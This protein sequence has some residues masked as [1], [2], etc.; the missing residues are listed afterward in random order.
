MILKKRIGRSRFYDLLHKG[1]VSASVAVSLVG[2]GVLS[3]QVYE[4][5]SGK[6]R[7]QIAA[8]NEVLQDIENNEQI[9]N[10]ESG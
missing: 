3:V 5:L 7:T 6:R 9:M 4:I 1:L 2:I 8:K 10:I